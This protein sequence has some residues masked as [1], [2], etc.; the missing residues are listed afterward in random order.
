[1][2]TLRA[3]IFDM[4]GVIVNSEPLHERAFQDLM[5]HL[6]YGKNHGIQVAD[7]I[8]RS[9]IEL[10]KDFKARHQRRELVRPPVC[11]VVPAHDGEIEER[12]GEGLRHRFGV[13]WM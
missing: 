5:E 3:V 12:V 7:Y 6:G 1:M 11:G 2:T 4:D 13:P 8:G 10:W 9:D